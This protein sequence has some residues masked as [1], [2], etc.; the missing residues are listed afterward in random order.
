MPSAAA[1]ATAAAAA[2]DT[3]SWN[4]GCPSLPQHKVNLKSGHAKVILTHKVPYHL[5]VVYQLI[6]GWMIK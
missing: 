5:D 4:D 1:A 6:S 3:D 2:A